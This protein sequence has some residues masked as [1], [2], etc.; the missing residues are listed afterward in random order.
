MQK[1]LVILLSR[2]RSGTNALRSVLESHP[3]VHCFNEIM[4][5]NESD[6]ARKDSYLVFARQQ[7]A[8]RFA[9]PDQHINIFSD[10][11]QILHQMHD[12]EITLIDLKYNSCHH[13]SACWKTLS[14]QPLFTW[15]TERQIPILRLCRSNYL[16]LMVSE[17]VAAI[18]NQWHDAAGQNP[19]AVIP[20]L[21]NPSADMNVLLKRFRDWQLEDQIINNAFSDH[22]NICRV[23][24]SEMFP[25][26]GCPVSD[27]VLNR[28]CGFLDIEFDFNPIPWTAKSVPRPLWESIANWQQVKEHLTGTEFEHFLADEPMFQNHQQSNQDSLQ[29]STASDLLNKIDAREQVIQ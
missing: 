22:D 5:H 15:L 19:E 16:K 9:D 3:K 8:D 29:L 14:E 12:K 20:M 4:S 28:I 2:Q 6:M 7:N 18:R 25:Q 27:E 17:V 24:Y 23:S 11:V 1:K 13:V 10:F 21:P 26:L